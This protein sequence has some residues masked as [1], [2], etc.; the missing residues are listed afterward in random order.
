MSTVSIF[1]SLHPHYAP[2]KVPLTVFAY[3]ASCTTSLFGNITPSRPHLLERNTRTQ[4][5][6]L[7]A[8]LFA[9]SSLN[10]FDVPP[11]FAKK[12]CETEPPAYNPYLK[13][14]EG[15]NIC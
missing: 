9:N 10:V 2:Y 1:W 5:L 8:L 6:E 7:A 11:F 13:R 3:E 14:L 4:H 12:D 15:L